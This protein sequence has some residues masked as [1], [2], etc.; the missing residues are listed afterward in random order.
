MALV[1]PFRAL[2]YNPAKIPHPEEVVTPPYDVIRPEEREAFAALNPYNMVRLILPQPQPGD[3]LLQNRYT[4]AAATFR[5]WQQEG[6][7]V[8]DQG[9][10]YYYWETEFLVEGRKFTRKGLVAM[11]RL[12]PFKSGVIL[13]HEQTFSAPKADRLEL[14]KSTQTHFSPIFAIYPDPEDLVLGR[15]RQSLPAEPMMA[16]KD[17]EG[18][19]QRAFRVTD[20]T[21]LA[22]VYSAFQKMPLFI[23]DGHHRYETALNYQKWLKSR[24]P[25]APANA[26]FNYILMYLSNIFDPELVILMAHRLLAGP[27]VKQVEEG[28]LLRRLAEYFEVT[29]LN[30]PSGGDGPRVDFIQENLATAA[31]Q[32]TTFILLGFGLKAWRLKLRE[33]VRQKLLA[34]EMHPA[35]AQLDVVVLNYLIFEKIL[36]L[37]SQAL[38][39][40]Q[41]CKFTSKIP[42]AM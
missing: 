29:P 24:Y 10:G 11:V 13:P 42:E 38:D 30:Y 23:A 8:R 39:N 5:Q 14:L 27:R 19:F 32:E 6:V 18:Y 33:G 26:S 20:R 4:R 15:L 22:A 21:C 12:E 2:H 17:S 28:P 31:P 36:G 41:T 40:Q 37:D 34:R 7:L 9:P 1:A 25:Q 16:F 3:D 35:L